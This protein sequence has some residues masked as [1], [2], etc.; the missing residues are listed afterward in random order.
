MPYGGFT[1]SVLQDSFLGRKVDPSLDLNPGS[2]TLIVITI[3]MKRH[4]NRKCGSQIDMTISKTEKD[5]VREV[6]GL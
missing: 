6:R 5:H 2:V 3:K 1:V 4:H